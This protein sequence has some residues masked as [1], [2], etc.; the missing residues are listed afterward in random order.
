MTR[1]RFRIAVRLLPLALLALAAGGCAQQ[2]SQLQAPPS[3]PPPQPR[4]LA[5]EMLPHLLLAESDLPPDAVLIHFDP[6]PVEEPRRIVEEWDSL[7]PERGERTSWWDTRVE[8]RILDSPEDAVAAV[9]ATQRTFA[10]PLRDVSGES[11]FAS[12][13]D[14]I[15]Y[16]ASGV[17]N[18]VYFTRGNVMAG[19]SRAGHDGPDRDALLDLA[20]TVRRKIEAAFAGA[21]EPAPVLPLSIAEW[22][23]TPR[24]AGRLRRESQLWGDQTVRIGLRIRSRLPRALP[25]RRMGEDDYLVPLWH[26]WRMLDLPLELH[27]GDS[28]H[29]RMQMAGKELVFTRGSPRVSVDDGYVTLPHPVQFVGGRTVVPLSFAEAVFGWRIAGWESVGDTRVARLEPPAPAGEPGPTVSLLRG[30]APRMLPAAT[31]QEARS[32]DPSL[33]VGKR[34]YRFDEWPGKNGKVRPSI[35]VGEVLADR[36]PG[37]KLGPVPAPTAKSVQLDWTRVQEPACN[38]RV[39][40]CRSCSDAHGVAISRLVNRVN[41]AISPRG[42]EMGV[43]LGDLSFPSDPATSFVRNNIYVEVRSDARD[44]IEIAKLL[45]RAVLA[46]PAF[47]SYDQMTA[48]RPEVRELHIPNRPKPLSVDGRAG[49]TSKP[50]PFVVD[51]AD[52]EGGRVFLFWEQSQH[53]RVEPLDSGDHRIWVSFWGATD[54]WQDENVIVTAVNEL[55]LASHARFPARVRLR[56]AKAP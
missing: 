5:P 21:P 8:V 35:H 28:N 44:S 49:R 39:W 55:G 30:P 2:R 45:D 34:A 53:L 56:E 14:R 3:D 26:L 13:G 22:R 29:A 19:I 32:P 47:D 10:A 23:T 15:W 33:A 40:V 41:A 18:G 1:T 36:V 51:V 50:M 7:R 46:R 24:S 16:V 11:P 9:L 4:V 12:L 31:P 27:N 20:Q 6:F 42:C 17:G 38:V 52:P 37:I 25:A 54:G 48:F 43:A